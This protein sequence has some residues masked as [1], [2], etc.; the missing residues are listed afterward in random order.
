M[1]GFALAF[2]GCG[3]CGGG[4]TTTPVK[5]IVTERIEK[6][7]DVW[8]VNFTSKIDAPIEQVWEAFTQPER[9]KELAPENV[10]KSEVVSS[11][12]NKKTI[13]LVGTLDILPPGFK[14]QQ[15]VTEYT[16]FPDEKRITSKTIDFKLADIT[17]EYKFTAADGGKAT[18]LTFTQESKDKAAL[19]VASLQKGALR[20]TYILQI[21]VVNRAL[22]LD[23]PAAAAAQG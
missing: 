3:G 14:M 6:D 16:F 13:D 20:E 9:A 21:K 12:G 1:L 10:K 4:E 2:G 11:E 15:V 8:K 7:G 17:S 23:K 18:L 5:E 22:G 19:P